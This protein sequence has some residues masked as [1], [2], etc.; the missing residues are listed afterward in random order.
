MRTYEFRLTIECASDGSAD[1]AMVEEMLDLTF[2]EL[3]YD[4]SF[5]NALG[6]TQSVTIQVLP[7]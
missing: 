1:L 7:N 3:V 4:D 6:E 5:V 2:K